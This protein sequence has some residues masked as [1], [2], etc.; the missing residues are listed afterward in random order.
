MNAA[1]RKEKGNGETHSAEKAE[2]SV[3]SV[4]DLIFNWYDGKYCNPVYHNCMPSSRFL[5]LFRKT[6]DYVNLL[7]IFESTCRKKARTD[8]VTF[9][10][11]KMNHISFCYSLFCY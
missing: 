4:Q 7:R 11:A 5:G 3:G 2:K 8:N 1:K 6:S 10:F 9:L